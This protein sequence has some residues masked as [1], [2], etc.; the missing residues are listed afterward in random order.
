LVKLRIGTF[1]VN[2]RWTQEKI[3]FI[4]TAVLFLV[5]VFCMNNFATF[6]NLMSLTQN[7]AILGI[8]G[9]GMTLVVI[10]RGIDLSMVAVMAISAAWMI[11]QVKHGMPLLVMVA[12]ALGFVILIGLINGF[13]IA[14]LD[15]PAIFVTLATGI[16]TYGFGKLVLI[17][18][19]INDFSSDMAFLSK[20]GISKILGIPMPV[21]YFAFFCGL[22]YV[23]LRYSKTGRY[24]YCI[25]D[26]L[27]ASRIT[28]IPYRPIIVLQYV[29]AS[30]V[31]L[32]AG[33][34]SAC[35]VNN[36]NVK[37]A[38]S[39]LIYDVI[40]V[41]ILGGISL[42]GGK[43]GIRNV[44]VGT[45]LIGLVSNVM[46]IMNIQT[47]FQDIGKGVVLLI[48]LLIDSILN[49]REEQTAQQGDI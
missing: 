25:G 3:V 19:D 5:A 9:V 49:P 7:V 15:I 28:G 4:I 12:L 32:F 30:V 46:T 14:Y 37:I 1:P 22:A 44:I 21:I 18:D 47:V 20:M 2:I 24:I 34:V 13:L 27:L 43:G 36:M 42:S 10:G 41:V 29:L 39:T 35:V 45:L 40:L 16:I 6:G 11:D 17:N 8:L 31:S 26:N 23:F 48:A 38:L 33:M